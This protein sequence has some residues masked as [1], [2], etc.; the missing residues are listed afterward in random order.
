[1]EL[2]FFSYYRPTPMASLLKNSVEKDKK[3][4]NFFKGRRIPKSRRSKQCPNEWRNRE[5][6]LML[7]RSLLTTKLLRLSLLCLRAGRLR[8]EGREAVILSEGDLTSLFYQRACF[9]NGARRRWEFNL[10]VGKRQVS[11]L[12]KTRPPDCIDSEEVAFA[13][14]P[15]MSAVLG[16]HRE[17][18]IMALLQTRFSYP[19]FFFIIGLTSGFIRG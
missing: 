10:L 17:F 18:E 6:A 11:Y 15:P 7:L 8:K 19:S 12:F 1:M 9:P 2:R 4:V 5:S 3:G 14:A 16:G 13:S